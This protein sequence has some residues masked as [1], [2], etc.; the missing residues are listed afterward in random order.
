M[1]TNAK[2]QNVI[3]DFQIGH[4]CG[5]RVAST[6]VIYVQNKRPRVSETTVYVSGLA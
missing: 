1:R 2:F 3:L 6:R 5:C 4:F